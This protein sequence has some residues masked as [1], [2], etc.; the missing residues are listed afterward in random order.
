MKYLFIGAHTDDVELSCGGTI[1]KL[2]EEN[3]DVT[4][5]ALSY[6]RSLDLMREFDEANEVL[7][8]DRYVHAFTC[9][10]FVK[11]Q[12]EIGNLLHGLNT[13][14]DFVFTHSVNDRHSD[15]KVVAE[16]SLRVLNYNLI[17]YLGAWNGQQ[18]E[19]HFVEISQQQLDKKIEALACY[20]SQSY[21]P[22]M[23]PE[24]IRAQ[25]IFNGIKCNKRFAEAFRIERLIN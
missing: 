7:G 16:Q 9:R 14:F 18:N 17:T 3:H 19:N 6:C 23:S 15:H 11:E 1:A 24:F 10:E 2:L 4:H 8:I 20:E 13:S 5:L 12:T 21:R 22:Y 25:A